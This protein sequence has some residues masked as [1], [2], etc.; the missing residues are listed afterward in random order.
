MRGLTATSV[1]G[2]LLGTVR[3]I[4]TT[5]FHR[6]GLAAPPTGQLVA[7]GRSRRPGLWASPTD[8]TAVCVVILRVTGPVVL[9]RAR[10]T[11]FMDLVVLCEVTARPRMAL[12]RSASRYRPRTS[13][14]R[15]FRPLANIGEKAARPVSDTPLRGP[16]NVDATR[17]PS[18]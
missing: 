3:P 8:P 10:E 15:P 4:G 6:R 1:T 9:T 17:A 18:F 7:S 16:T 11:C 13:Q 14:T 12:S 5:L 2:L